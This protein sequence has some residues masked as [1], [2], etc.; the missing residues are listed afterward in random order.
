MK[1]IFLEKMLTLQSS[2]ISGCIPVLV[3]ANMHLIAH[4]CFDCCSVVR[5]SWPLTGEEL[6]QWW[7][8]AGGGDLNPCSLEGLSAY[9]VLLSIENC[10]LIRRQ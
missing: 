6:L 4:W 2:D 7:C 9:L 3:S 1:E 10:L 8:G 5:R